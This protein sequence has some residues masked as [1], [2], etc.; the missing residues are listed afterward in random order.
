MNVIL[1]NRHFPKFLMALLQ[2][3]SRSPYQFKYRSSPWGNCVGL[4]HRKMAVEPEV[5]GCRWKFGWSGNPWLR[6]WMPIVRRGTF[7]IWTRKL[8][9]NKHEQESR[10]EL[11]TALKFAEEYFSA[12]P[13]QLYLVEFF[14]CPEHQKMGEE[15]LH[16][17]DKDDLERDWEFANHRQQ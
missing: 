17:D 3:V 12:T 9:I 11:S 8:L 2:A 4:Q 14:Y 10:F 6:V 5:E 7:R 16:G 1:L 13:S 15:W